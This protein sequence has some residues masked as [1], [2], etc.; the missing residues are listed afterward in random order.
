MIKHFIDI[1]K[2]SKKQINSIINNAIKFKKTPKKFNK[3]FNSKTLGLF[4]QKQS[5]RTRLSFAA[6]IQ[7]LGGDF[8]ELDA[9][10]IGFG[11]RE[12]EEDIIKILSQYIDCLV[13]RNNNHKKILYYA[14]LNCIPIING[15]SNYSHPCQILSD[16]MTIKEKLGTDN[17]INISWIGDYNN[18]LRSLIHL[19]L[20]YKFKLNI[21]LPKQIINKNKINLK[22]ITNKNIIITSDIKKGISGSN[23]VMT[24]VWKSMGEKNNKKIS[25]LI[26]YQVNDKVMNMVKKEAIFM[27]CLP[28]HRGEEVTKEVLDGNKSV[29]WSQAKNRM[30]VQQAILKYVFD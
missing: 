17:E 12:S 1:D 21:I 18:V 14:S 16:F 28:A 11:K 24:D 5:T 7:K 3:L 15:L 22:K 25:Y 19:A 2:L 10:L 26:D 8:I 23:C 29:V 13:I 30:F 4:F 6:G 9:K 20:I 27:H